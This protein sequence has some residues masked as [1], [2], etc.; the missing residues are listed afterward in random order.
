MPSEREVRVTSGGK[1]R[2]V[3]PPYVTSGTTD[4][5]GTVTF[6]IPAGTF[7]TVTAAVPAVVRNT[8]TPSAFAW[9]F[10]RSQTATSVVVQV[11]E[12]KTTGVLIGGTIEGAEAAPA[13][14]TVT[15]VVYGT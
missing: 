4:S 13:G 14:V 7:A 10:V 5:S 15:L 12:S 3:A 6:T 2:A 1:L 8:S 11:A 9:A